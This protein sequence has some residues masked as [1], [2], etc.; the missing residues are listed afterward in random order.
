MTLHSPEQKGNGMQR[1]L[2]LKNAEVVVCMDDAQREIRNGS[3]YIKDDRIEAVGAAEELPQHAM[4]L[5][6]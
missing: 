4:K 3:I 1:T 6:I 2:L 5:S